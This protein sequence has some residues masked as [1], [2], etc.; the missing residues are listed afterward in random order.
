MPFDGFEK[1]G[2]LMLVHRL[3][4]LLDGLGDDTGIGGVC[5]DVVVEHGLFQCMVENAV[6]VFDGL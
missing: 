6:D 1:V 4:F 3:H 2:N 5:P